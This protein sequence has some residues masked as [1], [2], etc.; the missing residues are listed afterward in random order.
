MVLPGLG[1]AESVPFDCPRRMA[2]LCEFAKAGAGMMTS[3]RPS[4]LVSAAT[5]N[6]ALL[7]FSETRNPGIACITNGPCCGV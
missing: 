7:S 3:E 6:G 1:A 2:I 4:P 5:I